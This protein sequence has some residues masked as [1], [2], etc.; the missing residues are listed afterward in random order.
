MAYIIQPTGKM[1][2]L[3]REGGLTRTDFKQALGD[4]YLEFVNL[5]RVDG[6]PS[7]T[8]TLTMIV[9][10]SGRLKD[11]PFN[12]V[13]TAFYRSMRGSE[14]PIVGPALLC[15]IRNTGEDDERID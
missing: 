9:D 8:C 12:P 10:E 5:V 6:G 1:T 7:G 15:L 14:S 4:C 3:H 11:L 2:P 13:A